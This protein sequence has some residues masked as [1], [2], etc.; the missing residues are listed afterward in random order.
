MTPAARSVFVFGVYVVTVGILVTFAPAAIP[1]VLQF[2]PA[3][4][5]WIRM[6]GILSL[7]IGG[8]DIVS[9]RSNAEANVRASVPIRVGFAVCCCALV[10][11]RLMPPQLLPL[12]AIDV[13]GAVW[14]ALALRGSRPA[15]EA[16]A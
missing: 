9:G 14:T 3:T 10:A 11:L 13:A 4:D 8:Y 12:A 7:V 15:A 6:V 1:R 2:P 5:E 16:G